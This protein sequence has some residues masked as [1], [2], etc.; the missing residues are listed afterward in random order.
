MSTRK[1]AEESVGQ[2]RRGGGS[3]GMQLG[4]NAFRAGRLFL[5]VHAWKLDF[6]FCIL[7]QMGKR[8][9]KLS[10]SQLQLQLRLFFFAGGFIQGAQN[11][12]LRFFRSDGPKLD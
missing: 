10:V 4:G 11:G 12:V 5:E 8:H 9:H 6:F 3:Q 7:L 1:A 2:Y